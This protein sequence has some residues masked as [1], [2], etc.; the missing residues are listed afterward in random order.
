MTPERWRQ[1][2]SIFPDALGRDA[3][4]REAYLRDACETDPALREEVDALLNG[5]HEAG[6]F[7]DSPMFMVSQHVEELAAGS[8]IASQGRS[9]LARQVPRPGGHPVEKPAGAFVRCPSGPIDCCDTR[10]GVSKCGLSN[11]PDLK[12]RAYG[13]P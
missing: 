3:A 8:E 13:C 11:T 4:A 9:R 6:S 2:T 12:G 1:I 7:G 5:H 10:D